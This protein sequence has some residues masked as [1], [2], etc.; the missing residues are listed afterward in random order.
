MTIWDPLILG[1]TQGLTEFLPI[2]SSGHLVIIPDFLKKIGF[3]ISNPSVAFDVVLHFGTLVAVIIYM[4]KEVYSLIIGFK[5]LVLRCI[6]KIKGEFQTEEKLIFL[7]IVGSIPTGLMGIFL[8]DWFEEKFQ[9]I[10]AVGISL[11]IT[12]IILVIGNIW[13]KGVKKE[14][15][16]T[17]SF[18][19]GIAQGCAIM[20]G[21]SRSGITIVTGLLCGLEKEQAAKFSFLLSIPA[22]FGAGLIKIK[23]IFNETMMSFDLLNFLIGFIVSIICGYIAIRFLLKILTKGKLYYFAIYCFILGIIVFI[24]L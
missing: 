23:D 10:N 4:W 20:P 5:K 6:G 8:K 12:A 1:I 21:I 13:G 18:I 17:K 16:Y 15:S 22:I 9:N 11:I 3:S 7:L 19:I 24:V 14:V 2:S